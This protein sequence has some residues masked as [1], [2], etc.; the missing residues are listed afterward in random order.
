MRKPI[1]LPQFTAT[2]SLADGRVRYVPTRRIPPTCGT[3][4]VVA[5]LINRPGG[6]I[7]GCICV[8]PIGCP[9][10]NSLPMPL[11]AGQRWW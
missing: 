7:P 3:E 9:C 5:Q 6:C 4:S 2:A 10:C 8:S 11:P 1:R